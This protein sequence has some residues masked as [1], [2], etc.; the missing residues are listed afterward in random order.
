MPATT[1]ARVVASPQTFLPGVGI[2]DWETQE[3]FQESQETFQECQRPQRH[4]LWLLRRRSL[5]TRVYEP[6]IRARLGF[7]VSGLE[8]R[9]GTV[10]SREEASGAASTRT[11]PECEAGVT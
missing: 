10:R 8:Q 5:V 1:A 3:T 11:H 7:R 6:Q 2:L 4:E 9:D